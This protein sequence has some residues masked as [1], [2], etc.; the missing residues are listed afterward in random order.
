MGKNR[1]FTAAG[2]TLRSRDLDVAQG[3]FS[4]ARDGP[5]L[6][7]DIQINYKDYLYSLA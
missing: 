5:R 6:R 4:F 1:D 3:Y 2:G 7:Q